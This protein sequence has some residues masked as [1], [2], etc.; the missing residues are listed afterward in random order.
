M[1]NW[2][3]AFTAEESGA[4]SMTS[5][6]A[7]KGDSK[8]ARILYDWTSNETNQMSLSKGQQIVVTSMT[9][10]NWWYGRLEDKSAEGWE[11][12]VSHKQAFLLRQLKIFPSKILT[13]A[14]R[15]LKHSFF[16]FR[17]FP[18]SYISTD[19]LEARGNTP[20]EPPEIIGSPPQK[21]SSMPAS[22]DEER[23]VALFN[24]SSDEPGDLSFEAGE[25]ILILKKVLKH[26]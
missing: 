22:L 13:L 2:L 3:F 4:S 15:Y 21:T 14:P 9:E 5:T 1:T 6:V 10:P 11:S 12:A 26:L 19:A 16:S 8:I 7:D 18:S 17:Y 23:C 25:F 24:Y 20:T